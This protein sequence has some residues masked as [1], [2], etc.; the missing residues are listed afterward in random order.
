[1]CPMYN[2]CGYAY[3]EE[4]KKKIECKIPKVAA[5][6]SANLNGKVFLK[7]EIVEKFN[8]EVKLQSSSL[9]GSD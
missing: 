7:P 4:K 2:H 5:C 8:R 6:K 3:K 1:M 9:C